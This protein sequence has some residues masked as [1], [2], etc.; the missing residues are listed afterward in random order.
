MTTW[1]Y[2]AL[3]VDGTQCRAT[4]RDNW[5]SAPSMTIKSSSVHTAATAA[6]AA[7]GDARHGVGSVAAA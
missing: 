5:K 3:A 4:L 7:A 1:A 2:N 6:A